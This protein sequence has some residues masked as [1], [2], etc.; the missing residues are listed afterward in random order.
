MLYYLLRPLFRAIARLVIA[1]LGGLHIEGI[2]NVPKSGPLLVTPN[3]NSDCDP[4]VVGVTLPRLAYYM[5]KSELFSIPV[6]GPLI[7]AMRGFPV[8]RGTADRTALR[9]AESLLKVG[10]AVVVFPEGQ[11]SVTGRLQ[12][13]N[14]GVV[15]MAMHCGA[16]ILPVALIGTSR[17]LP[18]G[19][20]IP[21]P[22]RQR[23]VVRFGQPIS[24]EV[25]TGGLKGRE[26]LEQGIER[27]T[28]T[29]ASLIGDPVPVAAES[30]KPQSSVSKERKDARL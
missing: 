7:R 16:P 12:P 9:H 3:H 29:L 28:Q 20:L 10:E 27:L 6:L 15:M 23:I 14:P 19:K 26:G 1:L 25:L 13:L 11:L 21:R 24:I 4:I 8:R 2:E 5:A 22:A 30:M 18:Y 17:L